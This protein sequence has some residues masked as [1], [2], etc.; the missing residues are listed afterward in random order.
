MSA[1]VSA[2]AFFPYEGKLH[3]GR[4][5][6]TWSVS[7]AEVGAARRSSLASGVQHCRHT[8]TRWRAA[9]QRLGREP[10]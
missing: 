1:S 10:I 7:V 8:V 2:G 5:R 4:H 3:Q 9:G 6:A